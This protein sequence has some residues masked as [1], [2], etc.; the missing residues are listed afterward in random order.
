MAQKFKIEDGKF[1]DEQTGKKISSKT[2]TLGS[3]VKIGG[4][5]TV[6]TDA[7]IEISGDIPNQ[8]QFKQSGNNIIVYVYKIKE[9][10]V[11]NT[12]LGKITLKN[13]ASEKTVAKQDDYTASITTEGG[14][15]NIGNLFTNVYEKSYTNI[16]K[17]VSL[18]GTFLD[19]N[20][21]GSNKNDT[22]KGI[23]GTNSIIGNRG[24]D[25]MYAGL[26]SD[27]FTIA[28]GDA[29][30]KRTVK[31]S[32]DI[33]YSGKGDI[34][35]NSNEADTLNMTAAYIEKTFA[36]DS[37]NN[38][39]IQGKYYD[40]EG[41]VQIDKVTVNKYFASTSKMYIGDD[42]SISITGSG[43]I[44]GTDYNDTIIGSSKADTITTGAGEDIVQANAGNDIITI[45]GTGD[46]TFIMS[47]GDG[48]DTISVNGVSKADMGIV[49]L[50]MSALDDG[51]VFSYKKNYQDLVITATN[52]NDKTESVTLKNYF[53]VEIPINKVDVIEGD[54]NNVILNGEDVST[55]LAEADRISIGGVKVSQLI[56]ELSYNG[57]PFSNYTKYLKIPNA[58]TNANVFLGTEYNDSFTGTT[59]K[60][61]MVSMGGDEND[62]V[63]GSNGQTGIIALG[64]SDDTYN[65]S[66]FNAGTG[67]YDEDG[68]YTL[69]INGADINNLHMVKT[70]LDFLGNIF[71]KQSVFGYDIEN[72]ES[73]TST[74]GIAKIASLDLKKIGENI[75]TIKNAPSIK[76]DAA[77]KAINT[78]LGLTPTVLDKLKGVSVVTGNDDFAF[79][80]IELTDKGQIISA[81]SQA[82]IQ[83]CTSDALYS[84]MEKISNQYDIEVTTK[85][86]LAYLLFGVSQKYEGLTDA[87]YKEIKNGFFNIFSNMYVGTSGNNSYTIKQADNLA[88]A[89]GTGSDS[90]TFSGEIGSLQGNTYNIISSLNDG[91]KDTI[92][93]KNLT[94]GKDLE[95]NGL[96]IVDGYIVKGAHFAE[97]KETQNGALTANVNYFIG[98]EGEG[99]DIT[100]DKFA[101]TIKDKVRTIEV[102]AEH[103]EEA[104]NANWSN[105]KFGHM[106]VM[107]SDNTT[108]NSN[109]YENEIEAFT[110]TDADATLTYNYNNGHDRIES[111]GSSDGTYNATLKASTF[112][113]FRDYGFNDNDTL[114]LANSDV[115]NIKLFFDADSNGELVDNNFNFVYT[116]GLTKSNFDFETYE[117][118]ETYV[119]VKNS[120]LT[121]L[122]L[123]NESQ[124]IEN[125]TC[126]GEEI[127]MAATIG[128]IQ[129][130]IANWFAEYDG[131]A[132]YNTVN[133]VLA[134]GNTT[135]IKGILACYNSE[136]LQYAELV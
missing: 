107:F 130:N 98:E 48:N 21:V 123:D 10:G 90:F 64:D 43:R 8:V 27:T 126:G 16:D 13:I 46:K 113:E 108:I 135:D 53:D 63:T 47:G 35:Y 14:T 95:P 31:K 61:L 28:E 50:F 30:L 104:I 9:G 118:N 20:F 117:N 93:F 79:E 110:L 69:S 86:D 17:A 133:D 128:A 18:K 15:L 7:A 42:V 77:V 119:Y 70:D 44:D 106:A 102:T 62:F 26:G 122:N 134:G 136:S 89:S 23:G 85:Q 39:I 34:I 29:T 124:G 19:E 5:P 52:T 78:L 1:I 114:A 121:N 4:V 37:K 84:F 87:Q 111:F 92:T 105:D 109:S 97:I 88:I 120:I 76:D 71:G 36:K 73:I 101:M 56:K 25:N 91:D 11:S 3:T 96:D 24:Y 132:E 80:D 54:Y 6:V 83:V 22:I 60:D 129:E 45:N 51:V 100:N 125:V 115:K 2:I 103:N 65:V 57:T 112:A 59:G 75:K 116:S 12:V 58:L 68:E 81:D 67:I 74:D 40:V 55:K 94:F 82:A 127:D 131:A 32:G 49:N 72:I 33:V 41:N 66:S 38:L 99:F